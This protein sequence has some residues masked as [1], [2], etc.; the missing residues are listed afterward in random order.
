MS[1]EPP[2]RAGL[3]RRATAAALVAAPLVPV[4]DNLLHPKE[5]ETGKGNEAK[6]LA[7]I[8]GHVER[9][10]SAHIFGFFASRL[11]GG[12]VLGLACFVSR[13]APSPGLWGGEL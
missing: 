8:A 4:V 12:A 11:Y 13:R 5:R 6:R 10:Q 3:Y 9:W 7:G 2:V 1:A